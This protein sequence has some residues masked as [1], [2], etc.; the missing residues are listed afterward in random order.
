MKDLKRKPTP[1]V[2]RWVFVILVTAGLVFGW[3]WFISRSEPPAEKEVVQEMPRQRRAIDGVWV[4]EGTPEARPLAVVIENSVDAWPISGIREANLVWE[5]PTEARITR[6]LAVYADGNEVSKIGPV[7]SARPYFSEWVKELGGIFAHVGGSPEALAGLT[8]MDE[9]T[10]VNEFWNGQYFWRDSARSR[11]HNVYTSTTLFSGLISGGQVMYEPWGF[12]D[13]APSDERGEVYEA[14]V[15][16]GS[17]PYEVHW[18]YEH[19][20]N[21]YVRWQGGGF[22]LDEAGQKVRA[23]NIVVLEDDISVIDQIGRLK[24]AGTGGRMWLFRDGQVIEGFWSRNSSGRT[25][26]WDQQK[27][28]ALL[29]NAGMIWISVTDQAPSYVSPDAAV[30][31]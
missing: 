4:P 6:F 13:E 19:E 9:V 3:M 28:E 24:F 30:L 31:D 29:L 25:R 15:S 14:V 7:R 23:K 21:D 12:K 5:A 26:F 20:P 10:D 18:I 22:Y 27:T 2:L 11:P 8:K 17:D 16:F 1:I